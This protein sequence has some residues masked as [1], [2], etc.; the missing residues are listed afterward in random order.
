MSYIPKGKKNPQPDHVRINDRFKSVGI[1]KQ[2][3]I[4]PEPGHTQKVLT[5]REEK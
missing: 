1:W 4:I 3:G 5:K 2:G